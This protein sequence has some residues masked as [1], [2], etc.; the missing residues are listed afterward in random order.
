MVFTINSHVIVWVVLRSDEN[1]IRHTFERTDCTIVL[2]VH[3]NVSY[4]LFLHLHHNSFRVRSMNSVDFRHGWLFLFFFKENQWDPW[5][6]GRI[7]RTHNQSY[8]E[9]IRKMSTENLWKTCSTYFVYMFEHLKPEVFQRFLILGFRSYIFDFRLVLESYLRT[10]PLWYN[11]ILH[12][13]ISLANCP[14]IRSCTNY[15]RKRTHR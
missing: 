3:L 13:T 12:S 14:L 5:V 7:Q 1:F 2:N 10:K 9:N 11:I 8:I 4:F 15:Q 6:F